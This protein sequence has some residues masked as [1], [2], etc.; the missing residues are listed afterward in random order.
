MGEQDDGAPVTEEISLSVE[1]TN[2][3]RIS[4][5]LKPLDSSSSG[6]GAKEDQ[7]ATNFINE[8][9]RMQKRAER[10]S[11]IDKLA[12]D[13]NKQ[14]FFS[15]LDGKGLGDES[16][17]GDDSLAWAMRHKT[18]TVDNKRK[19]ALKKMKE[20]E[21]LDNVAEYSGKDLAGLKVAHGVD[22]I[23]DE[24]L[25]LADKRIGDD[26]D[27]DDELIS[28]ALTAKERLEQNL[29][30]KKKKPTYNAYDDDEFK[31]PGSKRSLL[32]HYD[33]DDTKTGFILGDG[34][35]VNIANEE[36]ESQMLGGAGK[37]VTLDYEKMQEI[38]DY[39]TKEEA[40]SFMKP[41]KKKKSSKGKSRSRD[42][43]PDWPSANS[44]ENGDEGMDV[45]ENNAGNGE[46]NES[47]KKTYSQ[48]NANAD[49]Q[50]MN[51]V[52]DDDL[53]SALSR[54]RNLAHKKMKRPNAQEILQAAQKIEDEQQ[55]EAAAA[56]AAAGIDSD[57]EDEEDEALVLTATSEF[58]NSIS[59]TA[60]LS[61]A[62]A[63]ASRA[64]GRPRERTSDS[65]EDDEEE[66][67]KQP[68]AA[69]IER[70]AQAAADAE[71][72]EDGESDEDAP[73]DEEMVDADE[74][75][76]EEGDDLQGGG[77]EEE[78]L[79]ASGLAATVALLAKQGHLEKVS[80]EQ[81][82]RERK[83]KEQAK[84]K[85]EQRIAE[86]KRE[87]IEERRKAKQREINKAKGPQGKRGGGGGGNANAED[88]WRLEEETRAADRVRMREIEDRFKNYNPD[89]NLKYNDEYG[90]NLT[91]K[92]A[93]R[94]LSHKFH[95]KGSGKM[96]TEKR[97]LKL[98]EEAKLA[99]TI[100]TDTPLQTAT[101]LLE[102]TKSTKT[103]HVVLS[104]GNRGSLPQEVVAA[105]EAAL[106][107]KKNARLAKEAAA[108]LSKAA[109]RGAA[110]ASARGKQ[111]SGTAS[112][113]IDVGAAVP[114]NSGREKIAFGIS[115]SGAKRKAADAGGLFED[116]ASKKAK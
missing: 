7:A 3:L 30:N 60:P 44:K 69:E 77:I 9:K 13:E 107:A 108:K 97:L 112:T 67:T 24:I 51:F 17:E 6:G 82:E 63:S 89:V 80:S 38:K 98:D 106:I 28:S 41:K 86:R 2:K 45:D 62:A 114:G 14:K 48:S 96:K 36:D 50:N 26:D 102:K 12:R 84:W 20:L 101:A 43:E 93:F 90:N 79:V 47:T 54:A 16:D 46:A 1:E 116:S 81:I 113:V 88:E 27:D 58:V 104:I 73:R 21:D 92:E 95:G 87:I 71:M 25:V 91:Q 53:Q 68:N 31:N 52:D 66:N 64:V 65:D 42:A 40:V 75:R 33:E 29:K 34:G 22:D 55:Q 105:E 111:S 74:A 59:T 15:K 110:V 5:G 49:T 32:S 4:L 94:F 19:M 70:R 78:P 109:A 10:K 57:D 56:K 85:A 39:Y 72:K 115:S 61:R 103:A 8:K 11:I 23:T 83:Q 37:S 35:N 76:S 18:A 100:S 99:K